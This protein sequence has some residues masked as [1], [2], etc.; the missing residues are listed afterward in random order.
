MDLH[1]ELQDHGR[2]AESIPSSLYNCLDCSL[3]AVQNKEKAPKDRT[4]GILVKLFK[5][6]DEVNVPAVGAST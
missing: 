6:D 3:V 5:M 2:D 1:L 4:K